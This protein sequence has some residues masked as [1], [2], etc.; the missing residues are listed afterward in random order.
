MNNAI[1]YYDMIWTYIYYQPNM[2]HPLNGN[3]QG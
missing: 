1:I 3:T 2:F